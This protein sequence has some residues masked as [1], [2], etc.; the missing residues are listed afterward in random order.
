EAE[1]E[2]NAPLEVDRHFEIDLVVIGDASRLSHALRLALV[3]GALSTASGAHKL[4]LELMAVANRVH[5]GID[6][7][8]P[9]VATEL[10]GVLIAPFPTRKPQGI[11]DALGLFVASR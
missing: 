5:I 10:A 6:A 8:G 4:R 3:N 9:S 7:E 1:R 11:G 2:L